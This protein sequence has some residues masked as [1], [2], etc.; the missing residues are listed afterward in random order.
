ML[1]SREYAAW[2]LAV[3]WLLALPAFA[4]TNVVLHLKNGDRLLGKIISEDSTNVVIT[5]TWIKEL[6]IPLSA[7]DRREPA[8]AESV[9]TIPPPAATNVVVTA[10]PV[11]PPPAKPVTA[12]APKNWK[13]NFEVGAN[14]LFGAVDRELYWGKLNFTYAQPYKSDPKK[15]F[16]SILDYNVDYGESDGVKSTDRMGGSVKTDF[17]V[18]KRLYLYN[19]GGM[20]YDNIRKIDL[21][22]QV[23]PGVGYHLFTMPKFAMNTEVGLNY[24]AQ[25]RDDADD[26]RSIYGR[27]AEDVTWRIFEKVTF[28][29]KF[30]FFPNLE[31]SG[32][33][34]ARLE[35]TLSFPL[36]KNF[37]LNFQ[38]ID[39][40][41]TDPARGVD[42]N[43]LQFRSS[44][45]VSF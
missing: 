22:Y 40:Y 34:R 7:V 31:E 19:L 15:F 13:A 26:T 1:K 18:G 33:W 12:V 5:T 9:A 23:G 43:E 17:D 36:V 21:Q 10:P 6:S 3:A 38:V 14:L 45:G 44:I 27:L 24:Q 4:Q 39:I 29:E 41:D 11:K 20:G 32:E 30:E 16:R 25:E 2:I 35:A 28:T 42:K 8:P 37:T